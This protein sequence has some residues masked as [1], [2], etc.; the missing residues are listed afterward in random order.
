MRISRDDLNKQLDAVRKVK[1]FIDKEDYRVAAGL[2]CEEFR[3]LLDMQ[4][5]WFGIPDTLKDIA[6]VHAVSGRQLLNNLVPL[7]NAESTVFR[8]LGINDK[9]S[10]LL[11]ETVY[12]SL[13]LA[14][15]KSDG[16]D[17]SPDALFTLKHA[18]ERATAIV[19]K[20]SDGPS[21]KI[22]D[23]LMSWKGLRVLAGGVTITANVL[24]FTH[25]G[26]A[27][28]WASVKVGLSIMNGNLED[29]DQL[30][31]ADI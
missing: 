5:F 12:V 18:L 23:F 27:I 20:K 11:L 3:R 15:V 2:L 13:K 22:R 19:C 26:G 7:V 9:D 29:I 21:G 28:S 30:S 25:D 14:L 24:I 4:S 31:N 6:G 17:P 8:K 10:K 16:F 1:E